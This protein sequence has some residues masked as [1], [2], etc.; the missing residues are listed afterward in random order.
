MVR[1]LLFL[2]GCGVCVKG[3]VTHKMYELL[4]RIGDELVLKQEMRDSKCGST[5]EAINTNTSERCVVR[6]ER[7]SR[8]TSKSEGKQVK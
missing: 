7:L 4:H 8:I 1:E 3:G 6:R 5:F 2:K